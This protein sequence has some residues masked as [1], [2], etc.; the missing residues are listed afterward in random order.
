MIGGVLLTTLTAVQAKQAPSKES[1]PLSEIIK[2]RQD[3][4]S[5]VITEL[6]VDGFWVNGGSQA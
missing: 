2:A 3:Q 5:D 6:E 4:K 1:K